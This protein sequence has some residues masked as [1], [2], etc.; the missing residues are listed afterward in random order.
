MIKQDITNENIIDYDLIEW[1]KSTIVPWNKN[2]SL[3]DETYGDLE[4]L[5]WLKCLKFDTCYWDEYT[6]AEAASDNNISLLQF[7]F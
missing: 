2:T 4:I 5:K 6:F 1:A 7:F 3:Y